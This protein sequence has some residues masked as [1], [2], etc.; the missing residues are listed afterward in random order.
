MN[1]LKFKVR[2]VPCY[3]EVTEDEFTPID[4]KSIVRVD[5]G[6]ILG[7]VGS[8]YQVIHHS[9]RI[10]Q[11]RDVVSEL[12]SQFEEK[13]AVLH[14]GSR[15]IS[16][17]RCSGLEA[18]I[19]NPLLN[20]R[21]VMDVLHPTITTW[22]TYDGSRS[23]LFHVGAER[24]VCSN[25]LMAG[26]R[27]SMQRHKHTQGLDYDRMLARTRKAMKSFTEHVV[28]IWNKM[29]DLKLS[30]AEGVAV[31]KQLRKQGLV[32]KR[33]V[34]Y[35]L[36]HWRDRKHMRKEEGGRSMWSLYN[37]FT[38]LLTDRLAKHKPERFEQLSMP[39]GNHFLRLAA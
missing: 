10:A 7:T 36:E 8:E 9:D 12:D 4:R 26:T 3:A 39:I 37:I 19:K 11:V 13:H 2:E 1:A 35:V 18:E 21:D 33:D 16:V 22:H 17:F 5:T 6:D 38:S 27:H 24:L 25:G 20:R 31:V 32:G 34:E 30:R 14:G 23:Q 15:I 29:A 28:P